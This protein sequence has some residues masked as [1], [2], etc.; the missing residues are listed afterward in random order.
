MRWG[1][2]NCVPLNELEVLEG[3][4]DAVVVDGGGDVV[5]LLLEGID[6]ADTK[7]PVTFVS[8]FPKDEN[9]DAITGIY[10]AIIW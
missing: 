10:R 6:G 8:L 9:N 5:G 4:A 3:G 1:W 7:V 2:K